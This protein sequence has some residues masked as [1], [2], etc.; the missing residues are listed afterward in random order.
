MKMIFTKRWCNCLRKESIWNKRTKQQDFWASPWVVTRQLTSCKWSK[1][2]LLIVSSIHLYWMMEWQRENLLLLNQNLW[3]RIQM[4]NHLVE[5]LATVAWLECWFIFQSIP[6]QTLPIQQIA[7]QGKCFVQNIHMK[8]HW[9]ASVTTW[10]QHGIKYLYWIQVP[11]F[12]S[13]IAILMQSFPEFM[14]MKYPLIHI[15]WIAELG[16]LSPL[17]IVL[18]IGNQ[19][20][21]LKMYYQQCNQRLILWLTVVESSSQSLI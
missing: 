6:V 8:W 9:S 3:L 13:C 4:D 7:V 16:L 5:I 1:L 17:P 11:M 15:L 12:A 10:K 21:R 19:I 2:I 18:F 14:G 20:F